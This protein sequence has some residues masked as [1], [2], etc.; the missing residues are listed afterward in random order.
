MTTLLKNGTIFTSHGLM[1]RDVFVSNGKVFVDS[2]DALTIQP[3]DSIVDCTNQVIIPGFVDVHVHLREP[4][5]FYKESI[6]SGTAAAAKGGY[7]CVCP[8]PNLN[9]AP[10]T[11]DALRV[12]LDLIERDAKIKVIPYGTITAKQDGRSQ[13]ADMDAMAPYVC[14][15]S[16][17]GK[18]IQTGD[19]MEEAME[20]AKALGKLIVA[21]CEDET[22]L[23]DGYIHQGNYAQAHNHRGICSESEWAQVARDVELAAKTGCG[24]HVCHISTKETVNIIREAK[25][26]GVNVTCE[27]GPHYLVLSDQDLQ[28][29][30]RFKMNPPLRDISDRDALV[31]GIQ[32]GTI[33]MIATDHA[34]HSQEEKAKGLEN[35]AFG[36]VGLE[37]AFPVLYTSLVKT[38]VIT[39][40]RLIH[41]MAI[42]P[43][44]RFGLPGGKI[45]DGEPADITIIDLE[46][47]YTID[48]DDFVS[49]GKATPF[50]G[51]QVQGRIVKTFVDGTI[52]W[53]K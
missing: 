43:R 36:I 14:G 13:L 15:F 22:L 30:G 41:L 49:K 33:D 25:A 39:L 37:T 38:G 11:L 6:A 34:P 44:E 12:Q 26:S 29:D 3:A 42:A 52:V 7:T 23:Y 10:S 5:F 24:Y 27:T 50:D 31:K 28:E 19:L 51:W 40:E 47:S 32:D 46:E 53:E 2:L 1:Q 8:M 9:P 35:S 4:G 18:G 17:D 45:A 21:H 20:K 16:D 48:K